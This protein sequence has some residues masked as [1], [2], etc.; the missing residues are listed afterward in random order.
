MAGA[1]VTVVGIGVAEAGT[2]LTV[3]GIAVPLWQWYRS[4]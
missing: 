4:T 2:G 1:G 3:T